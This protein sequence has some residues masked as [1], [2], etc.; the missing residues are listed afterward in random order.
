[1]GPLSKFVRLPWS[2]KVLLIQATILIAGIR[3]ALRVL[4]FT[5]LCRL[6]KGLS[7]Q[8]TG[9]EADDSTRERTIW[10]VERAVERFP[11]VGT[12]LT[13]AMAA[14]VLLARRGHD[15]NLRIGVRRDAAGR[16]DAHAWLELNGVVLIGEA[17]RAG[18]T[19]MP[20]LRGLS[21]SPELTQS[22]RWRS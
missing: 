2:D 18:F 14:H 3:T 19:P 10:A 17:G 7:R 5:V 1:M 22:S 15:S 13:Q 8:S 16:F 20:A 9:G 6:L 11:A 21:G 4:P 12:C